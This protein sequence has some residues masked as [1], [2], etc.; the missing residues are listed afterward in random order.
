[1]KSIVHVA[2]VALASWSAIAAEGPLRPFETAKGIDWSGLSAR[3]GE[4]RAEL[5][6]HPERIGV[7]DG[8]TLEFGVRITGPKGSQ[9][10]IGTR[11]RLL[12]G[13]R[14]LSLG[15]PARLALRDGA[16]GEAR[17]VQA[18]GWGRGDYWLTCDLRF[19]GGA[20][21]T[22]RRPLV[23]L[24]L[25]PRSSFPIYGN[26][27]FPK[28]KH[29]WRWGA[30]AA[31][32]AGFNMVLN[33]AID[34]W[35]GGSGRRG[36]EMLDR[37][38]TYGVRWIDFP[39]T[40]DWT[41]IHA[42]IVTAGWDL[43]HDPHIR[44]FCRQNAQCVAQWGRRLPGFAGIS[45]MDEPAARS[46]WGNNAT[47]FREKFL[48]YD[49]AREPLRFLA[50]WHRFN[51][52]SMGD[53]FRDCRDAI[54]GI[55]P[56]MAVCVEGHNNLGTGGGI[57][58][59]L[60]VPHL[61]LN[62]TH[63]YYG[64][65]G[66]G[67]FAT[68]FGCETAQIGLRDK[69]LWMMGGFNLRSEAKYR[70]QVGQALARGC[71]A[72]GYFEWASPRRGEDAL[73]HI[74]PINRYL[75][76][77]ATMFTRL[78]RTRSQV[79]VFFS[80]R[81]NAFFA[82]HPPVRFDATPDAKATVKA[83]REA[84]ARLPGQPKLE[85]KHGTIMPKGRYA[86]ACMTA[87]MALVLSG[88]EVEFLGEEDLTPQGLK[89]K[90]V[91]VAP[92][93]AYLS[94]EARE[95]LE[96][97]RKA[98]GT[99]VTDQATRL[100]MEGWR[101]LPLRFEA[102]IPEKRYEQRTREDEAEFERARKALV[103]AVGRVVRPRLEGLAPGMVYGWHEGGEA[104][105]LVVSNASHKRG[106]KGLRALAPFSGEVRVRDLPAGIRVR[107]GE[108]DAAEGGTEQS[109]K[110]GLAPGAFAIY[111]FLPRAVVPRL[112]VASVMARGG[113][114][115]IQVQLVGQEGKRLRAAVPIELLISGADGRGLAHYFRATGPD[116]SC[117]C[118]WSPGLTVAD[119]SITVV[120]RELLTGRSA[121]RV[122]AMAEPTHK[123]PPRALPQ[124]VV[125][126][127]EA[128]MRFAMRHRKVLLVAP[129]AARDVAVKLAEQIRPEFDDL[130]VVVVEEVRQQE[131]M[132]RV[133]DPEVYRKKY[134]KG[135]RIHPHFNP[136]QLAV[137]RAAILLGTE[138]NNPLIADLLNA[139]LLPR[140]LDNP[141]Y[142]RRGLI[143]YAW[144]PFDPDLDVLVLRAES[145]EMLER[146]V[147]RL[148]SLLMTGRSKAPPRR[149]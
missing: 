31:A 85:V 42:P 89:G 128:V 71:R 37:F 66:W 74:T 108:E 25:E 97:F 7:A 130:T 92:Q 15:E 140:R 5:L 57:Y 28:G 34:D 38:A 54:R 76:R 64:D 2:C 4:W 70:A 79:G 68:S 12:G 98:G 63:H 119:A 110:L 13:G 122:V 72:F 147:G 126:D 16:A 14:A 131:K 26:L 73:P 82:A 3:R 144:A 104:R 30:D 101:T 112:V 84:L 121:K 111:A 44:A 6:F 106:E 53:L 50:D 137:G 105:Y 58:A 93:L 45:L 83:I 81:N 125:S 141:L 62:T 117:E 139:N 47:V 35:N 120:A 32:A 61:D 22:L 138:K 56:G 19:P 87:F 41:L 103:E 39:S 29:P 27:G 107:L 88:Y 69:P 18:R 24:P 78:K 142:A 1:V 116:G 100:R 21:A 113:R 43:Y 59:P 80:V 90:R 145:G 102:C 23:V 148:R 9:G 118:H 51:C 75:E 124:I 132:P 36:A 86:E 10:E 20:E 149:R 143:Q 114:S 33:N 123:F 77:F 60:N 11:W 136:T 91:L 96:E 52:W 40:L 129:S 133:M 127:Q 109:W 95:A 48:S 17:F 135:A 115:R 46:F 49:A 55:E 134:G 146:L 94:R 8:E 67:P 65:Y 99:I